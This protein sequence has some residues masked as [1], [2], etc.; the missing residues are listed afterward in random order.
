MGFLGNL[1]RQS[2]VSFSVFFPTL[3]LYIICFWLG[4]L[5]QHGSGAH[6]TCTTVHHSLIHMSCDQV[7][8]GRFC[9]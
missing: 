7:Q 2:L 6:S 5:D 9:Y 8:N 4:H 3:F 1:R